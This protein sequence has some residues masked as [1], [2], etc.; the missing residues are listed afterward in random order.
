[1]KQF[2]EIVK[3]FTSNPEYESILRFVKPLK[4][5]FGINH[6]WYARITFAGKHSYFGTTRDQVED[7]MDASMVDHFATLRHP[8]LIQPGIS[9][10][11]AN[12]DEKFQK[13]LDRS[14]EKFRIHFSLT[15][16]RPTPDGV[17]S[18]GFGT[19][20]KDLKQEEMLL[21]EAPL[22][23][24]FIHV[25][26]QKYQKFLHSVDEVE[27]DLTSYLGPLFYQ[28]PKGLKLPLDRSL[29]LKE[30]GTQLPSFTSREIDILRLLASGYPASY[31][32]QQL[33]LSPRTIEN[34]LA[35]L[36]SKLQC[37]NKVELIQK[38]QDIASTGYFG[39]PF[40]P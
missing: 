23:T 39:A 10:M 8:S 13:I 12:G 7:C 9:L 18:F 20:F 14:W 22:L 6:F 17:E 33:Y 24:H 21:N 15:F 31:I 1:M 11:K 32:A 3:S 34:Y 38:T 16:N 36:K 29:F 2:R 27:A 19:Q 26:R 25:F 28:H 40:T 30:I 4:C 35:G 37:K 5:H